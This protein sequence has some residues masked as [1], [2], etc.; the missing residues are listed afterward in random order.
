MLKAI[1]KSIP[2]DIVPED[3][4]LFIQIEAK[5][6]VLEESNRAISRWSFRR[7]WHAPLTFY[8]M[9]EW[10]FI[11]FGVVGF[12]IMIAVLFLPGQQSST[13]QMPPQQ[14]FYIGG[15]PVPP[16]LEHAPNVK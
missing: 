14:N 5:T 13:S 6:K 8:R 2:I 11:V 7:W 15:Q 12:F 9:F 3:Q 1:E 16:T 4:Q 10:I